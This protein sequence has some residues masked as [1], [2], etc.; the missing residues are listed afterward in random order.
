[1]N[2]QKGKVIHISGIE[3]GTTQNGT[4]KRQT[5]VIEFGEEYKNHIAFKVGTK[6][7]DEVAALKVGDEVEI[8]YF[9]DSREWKGNWYTDAVLY[10]VSKLTTLASPS[11]N[12]SVNFGANIDLTPQD[13][14]LP[15]A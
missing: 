5:I 8:N 6:H 10:S 11:A 14:D 9:V 7:I 3:S 12:T 4:W 2:T 1:M 13:D 15:F